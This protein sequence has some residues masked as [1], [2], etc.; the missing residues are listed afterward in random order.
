[1]T[2]SEAF[3]AMLEKAQFIAQQLHGIVGDEQR[4]PLNPQRMRE[5][6][7]RTLTYD[8]SHAVQG[9]AGDTLSTHRPH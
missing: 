3:D 6:R 5:I 4:T 8:F 2:A 1:M 7:E 9:S